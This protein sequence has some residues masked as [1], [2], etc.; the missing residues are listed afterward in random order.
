MI[1]DRGRVC[2]ECMKLVLTINIESLPYLLG[3]GS[4]VMVRM[5][6]CKYLKSSLKY[7]SKLVGDSGLTGKK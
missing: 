2:N 3:D 4:H 7:A 6:C 1:A 5:A